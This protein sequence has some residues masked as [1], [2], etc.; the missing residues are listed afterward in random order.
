MVLLTVFLVSDTNENRSRRT[1]PEEYRFL[2]QNRYLTLRHTDYRISY[3]IRRFNDMEEIR[4]TMKIQPYKLSLNEFYLVVQF[5]EP[6]TD[7]YNEAF[8]TAVRMYPHDEIVNLNAANTAMEKGEQNAVL[9]H[10]LCILLSS[11]CIYRFNH[12]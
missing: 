9:L 4:R 2:L 6:G 11:V 10:F 5:Y 3:A 12:Q 1:F 8:E 7:G